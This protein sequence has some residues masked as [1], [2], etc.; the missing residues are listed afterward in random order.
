MSS[1]YSHGNY[2]RN[3]SLK[4]NT[5]AN[6][7]ENENYQ[8]NKLK[9]IKTKEYGTLNKPLKTKDNLETKQ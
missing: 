5:E 9:I 8:S 6:V 4:D 1:E 3:I 2:D 7:I